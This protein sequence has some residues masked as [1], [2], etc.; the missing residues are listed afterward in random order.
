MADVIIS[1]TDDFPLGGSE[2][3]DVSKAERVVLV[4]PATGVRRRLYGPFAE[5]LAAQ[6]FG[7]V[8]WDWRG[9]GDSRPQS[10][11]PFRTRMR[12]WGERDLAGV[13]DW[14]SANNPR[15]RLVVVGHSFGGQ[16]VGLA[17]NRDRVKALV[18]IGAQSGYWGHWPR[19]Q[20]YMY[21]AL[22]YVA[23]PLA[24]RIAGYFPAR[25]F[26][27]GEDLPRGVALQWA[28]WCRTPSYLSDWS[29]H[30]AF[31]APILAF[32]FT[33]DPF[34]PRRSVDALL[35]EYGSRDQ[36]HRHLR[37]KDAG[38]PE[39]GHFGFFRPNHVPGLWRN[40]ARWLATK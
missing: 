10:L 35:A 20:R 16:S 28:R 6:G 40:V 33:D 30:R 34:A 21:A 37:P 25:L 26:R 18:T 38:V 27:L 15:A 39:I 19:P 12:E 9:T 2:F 36:T 1:A 31:T 22:W 29:G 13:I 24:T 23:M 3:G 4:A 5:F 32:S 11:R 17:G 14:V 8:T 7:V